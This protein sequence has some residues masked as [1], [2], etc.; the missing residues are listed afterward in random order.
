LSPCPGW[1]F[2]LFSHFARP[3]QESTPL[4]L[5]RFPKPRFRPFC[6]SLDFLFWPTA[7]LSPCRTCRAGNLFFRLPR[8]PSFPSLEKA[9]HLSALFAR[10]EKSQSLLFPVG[11]DPSQLALLFSLSS[12]RHQSFFFPPPPLGGVLFSCPSADGD[13]ALP[14]DLLLCDLLQE[15]YFLIVWTLFPLFQLPSPFTRL[16][17]GSRASPLDFPVRAMTFS[18]VT[19]PF[20]SPAPDVNIP[21]PTRPFRLFPQSSE[22]VV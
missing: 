19:F 1:A 2:V 5:E 6:T 10:V 17:I 12:L 21:S 20:T 8:S 11:I 22:R 9:P 18:S 16:I 4:S 7:Q 15:D 13:S 3:L 14:Q